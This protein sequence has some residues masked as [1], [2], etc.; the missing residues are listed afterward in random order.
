MKKLLTLLLLLLALAGSTRAQQKTI[1]EELLKK[2]EKLQGELSPAHQYMLFE[3]F[4]ST[5]IFGTNPSAVTFDYSETAAEKKSLEEELNYYLA[6]LGAGPVSLPPSV[7]Y[8]QPDLQLLGIW[9][10]HCIKPGQTMKD[11]AAATGRSIAPF[12]KASVSDMAKDLNNLY[13]LMAVMETIAPRYEGEK[14]EWMYVKDDFNYRFFVEDNGRGYRI[15][16]LGIDRLKAP[17]GSTATAPQASAAENLQATKGDLPT[18]YTIWIQV[19]KEW[20]VS[21]RQGGTAVFLQLA[22]DKDGDMDFNKGTGW[23]IKPN[24]NAYAKYPYNNGKWG[25]AQSISA[26]GFAAEINKLQQTYILTPGNNMSKDRVKLFEKAAY[27]DD[28]DVSLP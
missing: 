11:Y 8:D 21:V 18:T 20:F 10:V 28:L 25:A 15:S 24:G 1:P 17:D 9:Q 12:K 5:G 4:A 16:L 2:L 13:D 7:E 22:S 14:Y 3:D 23:C 6:Q 27:F 19:Q 26:A